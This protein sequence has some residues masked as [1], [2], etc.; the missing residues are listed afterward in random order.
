MSPEIGAKLSP[1]ERQVAFDKEHSDWHSKAAFKRVNKSEVPQEANIIGSHT[2]Y[3][4]KDDGTAKARIVPWGHRD[5]ERHGIICDLTCLNPETFRILLSIIAEQGWDIAQMDAEAAFLQAKG[6]HRQIY[7]RPTRETQDPTGLWLLLAAAYGLADSGRLW[8]R[9]NDAALSNVYNLQRSAYE[10]TLYFRKNADQKLVCV[11]VVQVDNYLYGGTPDELNNFEKFFKSHFSIASRERINFSVL[12]CELKQ[13]S[14]GNITIKKEARASRVDT[15]VL[16]VSSTKSNGNDEVATPQQISTQ[17]SVIGKSLYIERLTNPV[18]Q[19]HCSQMETRVSALCIHHLRTLK[20][21]F[22]QHLKY[23]QIGSYMNGNGSNFSLHALSDAAMATDTDS[24]RGG[25]I[26]FGRCGDT[27]HP[28]AWNER[29]L[30]RVA[31]SSSTA[32]LLAASGTMSMLA[33]LQILK[34]ELLYHHKAEITYDSRALFDLTTTIHEPLEPLNKVDLAD[35]REVYT[36]NQINAV[37]WY[38]R[39][40]NI[41]DA[42]NKNNGVT[43]ALLSHVLHEGEYAHHPD[44]ILRTAEQ[45]LIPE[46]N[47]NS[48]QTGAC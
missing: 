9:T 22:N 27:V 31:R 23:A 35:M 1:S 40:N 16:N 28:I 30:R 14:A 18:L 19:Y 45:P 24:A 17:R 21:V 11:L 10:P 39:Q 13:D 32:E 20:S 12:G 48:S 25:Y 29:K 26:I 4:R 41:G 8:Y 42:L 6:F 33:Y 43:A 5:P 37:S 36:V 44:R 3:R 34:G 2:I 7:V 15:S 38:P 47:D 46:T